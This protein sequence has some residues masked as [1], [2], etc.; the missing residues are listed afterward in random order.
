MSVRLNELQ[1]VTLTDTEE[2]G[3]VGDKETTGGDGTGGQ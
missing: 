1:K 2:A 3:E